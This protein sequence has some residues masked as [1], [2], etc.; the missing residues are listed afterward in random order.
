MARP[1]D[2]GVM[3]RK[4]EGFPHGAL[5]AGGRACYAGPRGDAPGPGAEVGG[6]SEGKRLYCGFSGKELVRQ[7]KQ[8]ELI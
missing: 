8:A 4:G 2:R 7:G 1:E 3:G 5:E 6:Q